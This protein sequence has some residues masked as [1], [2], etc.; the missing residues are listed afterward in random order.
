M[1]A[2]QGTTEGTLPSTVAVLGAG[3]MGRQIAALLASAGVEVDL[4]DL[5]T[6]D[7]PAGMARQ[8][9]ADLPSMRPTPLFRDEDAARIRPGALHDSG[10]VLATAPWVIEAVVEDLAIKRSVLD[11]VEAQSHP[12]AIITTNT[13]GLPIASLAE[14]RS[15]DFQRR[16][17]GVH[18]FNPPRAMLLVEVIPGVASDPGVVESCRSWVEAGL[19]KRAVICRD[20]PNFIANR[21]GVF[22]LMDILHRMGEAG[23]T[24]DA[25]DAVTGPLLGRPSSASLRLCDLIGLDTLAH[26]AHTVH[27]G[28]VDDPWRRTFATPDFLGSMIESGQLGAK[29][30]G[31]F[32]KKVGKQI[33]SR[34]M[35]TGDYVPRQRIRL[36]LPLRGPL[37]DR[38]DALWDSAEPLT[39]FARD[40]LAT[41]VAY[42]AD[43]AHRVADHLE[44]VDRALVWGFNWEAGPLALLD[45][46]G[47]QRLAATLEES[48]QPVPD[49]LGELAASQS[50][51]Y[52]QTNEGKQVF[53]SKGN[54]RP[55]TSPGSVDDADFLGELDVLEQGEGCRLLDGGHGVGILQFHAGSLNILGPPPLQMA[56][57][58][59]SSGK[60]QSMVLCGAGEHLSAGADLQYLLRLIQEDRWSE[61]EAYLVLFQTATSTMR[62]AAIPVVAAGRGLALG[63]GC[64]F[65]LSCAGR[66]LAAELRIGLVEAK[67]GLIPG[68]GG[69][70][71]VVRRVGA[72]VE[73][74]FGILREGLMSDNARQ[75]QDF[76]LVDATDAIHM[77]GHRVIQH[78]VTTAGA[79]STGWTPP[80]P[81]DLS[82]AGQAGLSRLTDELDRARQEGSAT[83]HDVVVG[84]A[85]AHVLCGA[86]QERVSEQ[87]LLDLE[88]E[89]F[90]ALSATPAT[91]ERIIHMLETGKP[92]RN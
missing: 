68:A 89:Q 5:G 55:L 28:V 75:A 53:E 87:R 37:K 73:R 63:G 22:A 38:L 40:H 88:R 16:V 92:L 56:I 35:A 42:A 13:S 72:D 48:S 34:D 11:L 30:G 45:L 51:V 4:L 26:V 74:I 31:G 58:C 41:C 52:R 57:D 69:C 2:S 90:H 47:P 81:T 10:P 46:I 43:C 12:D 36:E 15:A 86:G 33:H 49:L 32:Y 67:V 62:H 24:V 44:D 66:A 27:D 1:T 50:T 7:D 20:T 19:G 91:R 78:A 77:D 70:K 6:A 8:A 82:T 18:F 21:L 25:V 71:E 61:L 29:T 23:L 65:S 59:V 9:I 54:Y 79:L 85:L 83:E 39:Q 14:G 76:G 80:A 3:V 60:L 17:L 64:E 84:T